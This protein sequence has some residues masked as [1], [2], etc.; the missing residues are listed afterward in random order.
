MG[1]KDV[2]VHP[3]S[4]VVDLPTWVDLR[5][6]N[7]KS[8]MRMCWLYSACSALT[9]SLD[10]RRCQIYRTDDGDKEDFETEPLDGSVAMDMS[11]AT[12]DLS[13]GHLRYG[14]STRPCKS[15]EFCA[16]VK[17]SAT[18]V[19]ILLITDLSETNL[20]VI[21]NSE[22]EYDGF[23]SVVYTCAHGY[24][25]DGSSYTAKFDPDSSTW[26]AVDVTCTFVDCGP[27][28][29]LQGAQASGS[30]TTANSEV[31]YSCLAGA[32]PSTGHVI[33]VTCEGSTGQ[34]S[35]PQGSCSVVTC[36]A[37]PDMDTMVS[38]L[39]PRSTLDA[40]PGL[41]EEELKMAFGGQAKYTCIP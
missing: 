7:V 4:R 30:R 16:P 11:S 29:V 38:E 25:R 27:P 28:P 18:Y 36:G 8:C 35:S 13:K 31:T 23:S 20:P 24:F 2:H 41:D 21:P 10:Q 22:T 34:W 5:V 32:V 14:C 37:P 19:C 39:T 3:G 26:S 9:F 17:N 1:W 15:S 33:K 12:A 6:P 40:F